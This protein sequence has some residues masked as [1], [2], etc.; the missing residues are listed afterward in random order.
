MDIQISRAELVRTLAATQDLVCPVVAGH[1]KRVAIFSSLIAEALGYTTKER[2][3]LMLA[4]ELHDIGCFTLS[5]TEMKDLHAF[6][7]LAPEKH[8]AVG[9]ILLSQ[10]AL[11]K[12]ITNTILHHHV[13]WDATK[14]FD[15]EGN[16]IPLD[17]YIIHLADRIDISITNKHQILTEMKRIIKT[18]T[19]L[20]GTLFCPKVVRAFEDAS[21]RDAFWLHGVH[22]EYSTVGLQDTGEMLSTPQLLELVDILTLAIDYKSRFTS[23]HSSGVAASAVELGKLAG[24]KDTLHLQ[25]AGQLHDLGK[26]IV[27]NEILE[28]NGPLTDEERA[29]IETHPFYTFSMLNQAKGLRDIAR[30]ASFHQDKLNGRGYPFRP[31]PEE[32]DIPARILAI[33]DIFTALTEDRPYRAGLDESSVLGIMRKMTDELHLDPAIFALVESN[34]NHLNAIRQAAQIEAGNRYEEFWRETTAIMEHI[35]PVHRHPDN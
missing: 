31:V 34:Y 27:P 22:S 12:D 28:K 15:I 24:F 1:G 32:Y 10:S 21:A 17:A 20:S 4:A 2:E 5:I 7:V 18:I 8:C 26:L 13:H 25:L 6:D 19:E 35:H 29:V 9:Y 3:R 30:T 11:F 16:P 33:S 23:T 14:G